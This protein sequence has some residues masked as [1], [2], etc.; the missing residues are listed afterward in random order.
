LLPFYAHA[1]ESHL[2]MA[3]TTQ[4][5]QE[6]AV[7]QS[8]STEEVKDL[9]EDFTVCSQE[10]IEKR[11]TNIA[12]SRSV[13]NTAMTNALKE[14]KNREKAA[15][16]IEND[17]DKKA[18]I[19]ASVTAYKNTTKAAQTIL[20]Q[21]RKVAWQEFEDDIKQCRTTQE[22]ELNKKVD[23]TT[24]SSVSQKMTGGKNLESES[25]TIKDALKEQFEAIRSLFN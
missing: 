23:L 21:A 19:K 11:D 5:T 9:P 16:A 2:A 13:Y 15:V 6:V 22:E 18:A 12:S 8:S 14:R 24:E 10:A 17:D 7:S 4:T 20:T 3:T 1:E 25:K